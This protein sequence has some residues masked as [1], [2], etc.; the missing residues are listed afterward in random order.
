MTIVAGEGKQSANF[1]QSGVQWSGNWG[2][3]RGEGRGEICFSSDCC[4]SV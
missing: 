4:F 2:G 3:G 1:E